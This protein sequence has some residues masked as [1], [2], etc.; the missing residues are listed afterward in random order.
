[1]VKIADYGVIVRLAGGKMGLVHISEVA[2]AYVRDV[3]EYFRENDRISVKVLKINDKGRYELST[4]QADEK[5]LPIAERDREEIKPTRIELQHEEEDFTRQRQRAP[6][7]FEE[8]L[9]RFLKDSEERQGDL[10]RN[11]ESKRGRR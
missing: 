1:V 2:D 6:V 5:L 4:R 9:S 10:K 11:I 3:R 8:R 7:N